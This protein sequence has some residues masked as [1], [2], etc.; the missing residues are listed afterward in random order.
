[1]AADGGEQG[2]VVEREN[3]RDSAENGGEPVRSVASYL[4]LVFARIPCVL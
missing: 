4:T 2:Q 3:G 1:V